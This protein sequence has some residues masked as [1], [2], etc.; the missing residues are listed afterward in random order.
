MEILLWLVPPFLVALLAMAWV[1]WV[2]RE[3][4]GAVDAD[5]AVRRMGVA[6]EKDP[7]PIWAT[8]STQQPRTRSTGVAIRRPER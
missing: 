1:G 4:R 5:E 3:G 7:P 6:L 2:S 8:D